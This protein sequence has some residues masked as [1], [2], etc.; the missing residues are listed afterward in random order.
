MSTTPTQLPDPAQLYAAL[1]AAGGR[2]HKITRRMTYRCSSH[3]CLLLD[4]L[5][6]PDLGEILFHQ[7]RFKVSPQ[8][9]ESTS[10]PEA[11][12]V[13]THDGDRHW[14]ERTYW[15]TESALKW[16]G[17]SISAETGKPVVSGVQLQCDHVNAWTLTAGDFWADWNAG[18]AE[19]KVKPHGHRYGV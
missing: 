3:G 19:L 18:H 8:Q 12:A 11:R 10:A 9:N 2:R 17:P 16:T 14:V 15:L 5:D 13:E 6:V 4:V 7:K 1:K